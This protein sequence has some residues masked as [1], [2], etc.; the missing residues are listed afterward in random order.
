MN[1]LQKT[2]A[3]MMINEAYKAKKITGLPASIVAAQ[4]I[5]ETAWGRSIPGD[6]YTKKFSYNLFGIKGT[7]PNGSVNIKTHEF[8]NGEKV[9]IMAKFRAYNDY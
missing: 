1:E 4:G 7:G 9:L 3:K 2:F 6:I 8:I 5:L